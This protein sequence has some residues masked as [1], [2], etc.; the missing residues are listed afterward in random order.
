L[1]LSSATFD[2]SGSTAITDEGIRNHFKRDL[3]PWQPI[4]EL[5]WNGFD[6][7]AKSVRVI[8]RENDIG[9]TTSVTVVD[10]GEGIDFTKPM[11]NFRRFNDSLKKRSHSTHGSKGR[12]RLAFHKICTNAVWHTKFHGRNAIIGIQSSSLSTINGREIPET[13]QNAL[14]SSKPQGTCVELSN[15]TNNLPDQPELVH[16][17]QLELGW[18][19]AFNPEKS[20]IL[21]ATPIS[22]PA[23]TLTQKTMYA[24]GIEFSVELIQ[25]DEKLNSEKSYTYLRGSDG[26]PL[27]HMPSSLN[28]KPGYHTSLLVSSPW[29]D[30]L[31]SGEAE[32]RST[33]N[34]LSASKVW[35]GFS[36]LLSAFTQNHYQKFLARL[37]DEQIEGFIEEGD[38]P[39]YKGVDPAY[40][41]WRLGNTKRIVKGII[42]AD[43]KLFK[44]SNKKQRKIIIRLLDK[45]SVSSENSSL[46]EIL[47]S[48][49]D[50][51]SAAMENFAAQIKRTK[52]QNI[53]QTIESL[54][55]REHAIARIAEIMRHHYKV[56]LETPDLQGVIESNTWLF[57]NQYES[58][59]AEE[60]TF[61]KIAEN[62]RNTVKDINLVD[63]DDLEDVA[64]VDGANRQVDLFLVRRQKQYDSNN[65]PYFRCVII[66]I[67]RPSVSLNT[68]HLRQIDDYAAILSRHP[69]FNGIRTKYEIVLVGRK[70]SDSNFDIHERLNNLADRNDPGLIGAG[71][72]TNP[73]KKYVKTWQTIIEEF[74]ISHDFMLSTLKTQRDSLEIESTKEELL[75]SL[76]EGAE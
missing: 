27:H 67:K 47:D 36:K 43:P 59:G 55:K 18:H 8:T 64:T 25:W 24:E 17:L 50:L 44:N 62:L 46:L 26:I 53:I 38:F 15:F 61:T 30:V 39:D 71:T 68:K 56:T 54:Q 49:L 7:G 76:T 13:E 5:I 22:P 4:A 23:H 72:P 34:D 16:Q 9:G 66:E 37:A 45:I 75:D 3:Q 40:S 20:L 58:I 41:S 42:L 74:R 48:V 69:E 32:L 31:S 28:H 21:N 1:T 51:D 6:A 60:D 35:K 73:I 70:I 11:D 14:L 12:G 2:F 63:K 52:L 29:L 33:F 19:L 10:D 57:G 65:Q